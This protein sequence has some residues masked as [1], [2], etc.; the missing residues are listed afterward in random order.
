[1]GHHCNKTRFPFFP[2]VDRAVGGYEGLMAA[3]QCLPNNDVRD[4]F[5]AQYSVLS[6]IWE[7]F[8]PDPRLTPYE[9]VRR[10]GLVTERDLV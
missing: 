4:K 10:M 9:A 1:M 5:A 8:S 2:G 7:A 6:T 3:Q